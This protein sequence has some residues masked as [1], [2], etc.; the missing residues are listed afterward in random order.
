MGSSGAAFR[1]TAF[2]DHAA[3]EGAAVVPRPLDLYELAGP[4]E[5]LELWQRLRS[6]QP[7]APPAAAGPWVLEAADTDAARAFSDAR[8][9]YRR[10]GMLDCAG[11]TYAEFARHVLLP[12]LAVA[13]ATVARLAARLAGPGGGGRERERG[14]A[15]GA[16]AT[17]PPPP[18]AA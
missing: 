7:A 17:D 3:G 11:A 9:Y 15:G 18:G 14:R 2:R 1:D 8:G 10:F 5:A 12:S 16:R 4:G 13:P 6:A